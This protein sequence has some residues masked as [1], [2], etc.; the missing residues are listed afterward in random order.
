LPRIGKAA[1]V[2]AEQL[3]F[4]QRIE[5]CLHADTLDKRFS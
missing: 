4:D 1:L 5:N 3:R 2:A